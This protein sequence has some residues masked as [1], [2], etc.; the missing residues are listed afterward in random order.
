MEKKD[1]NKVVI[2]VVS[3]ALIIAI[4]VGSTF[5][6]W[7]WVTS[8]EQQTYVN[9]AVQ[10]GISM[11]ITPTTRQTN[12]LYPVTRVN[13]G[14]ASIS[15]YA[16][17]TV[18]N[19]TG[20]EAR[21][22]FYLKLKIEKDLNGDGI[23]NKNDDGTYMNI[24]EATLNKDLNNDGDKTDTLTENL[25]TTYA[26]YIKYAVAE[27]YTEDASGNQINS[28]YTCA[29]APRFG[30]FS[31]KETIDQ[32]N[33]PVIG[34]Y[35]SPLITNLT[36]TGDEIVSTRFPIL[37][38]TDSA[39]EDSITYSVPAGTT[40][41]HRFKFWAWIDSSYEFTT[42]GDSVSDPLQDAQITVSWSDASIVKQV[43]EQE[44]EENITE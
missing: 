23:I 18:V 12:I 28:S 39:N 43:T 4:I 19:H 27:Y 22:Q 15:G 7:Q 14:D 16:D 35:D 36:G 13:C 8:T 2:A 34:W 30:T 38:G 29:N 37:P 24:S 9:I 11:S 41:N 26:E 32:F 44:L 33:S 3:V 31:T 20:V 42:T 10:D 1:M 6:Y 5:A 25:T 21:P 40:E 17:V